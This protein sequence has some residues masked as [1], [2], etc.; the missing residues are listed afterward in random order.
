MNIKIIS[1][2]KREGHVNFAS[3]ILGVS[4]EWRN[5]IFGRKNNTLNTSSFL[6]NDS[7]SSTS[8]LCSKHL[9]EQLY[10]FFSVVL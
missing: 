1:E 9:R 3:R 2:P 7:I 5:I 10:I 8:Y 4:Q 6:T